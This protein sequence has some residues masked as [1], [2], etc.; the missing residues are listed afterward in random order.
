MS[1]LKTDT[2]LPQTIVSSSNIVDGLKVI[3]TD[4]IIGTIK[5]SFDLHNVWVVYD[6]GGS[7]FYCIDK[8]CKDYDPLYYC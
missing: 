3:D 1:Q 6:V 5:Q 4:G 2:Q 8:N 7:G